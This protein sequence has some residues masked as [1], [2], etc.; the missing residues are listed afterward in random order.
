MRKRTL[1]ILFFVFAFIFIFAVCAGSAQSA[2]SVKADVVAISVESQ[3]EFVNPYSNSALAIHF[4]LEDGW[5]FYGAAKTAPGQTNLKIKT[6]TGKFINF[7][8]PIFPASH[9]YFDELSGK[10]IE[11]FSGDFTVYLPFKTADIKTVSKEDIIEEVKIDISGA[12]CSARQCRMPDFGRLSTQIKISLNREMGKPKFTLPKNKFIASHESRTTGDGSVLFALLLAFLAGLSL[13]IMPCVW[14]ILPIIVMQLAR[15][16]KTKS[17]ATGVSFC[18]GILLFFAALAGANIVLQIFYGTVLQWGDV[19]RNTAFIIGIS[20][21][22][23]VLALFC[24]GLFTFNVPAVSGKTELKKAGLFA[25]IGAGFLAAVLSTPCSFALLAAA[26]AWAQTQK[27]PLATLA[28]MT[29]GLGMALPY[30]ALSA[31]PKFLNRL[32]KPGKW[33]ELFKQAIGFVLLGIAVKLISALPVLKQ[34]NILYFAVVLG[35]CVWVW[36]SWVAHNTKRIRKWLIR[37]FAVAMAVFFGFILLRPSPKLID[38]QNYDSQKIQT[39]IKN[40]QPVLI[41]FTA[42]WCLSCGLVEKSVYSQKEIV[43]LLKD[44]NVLTIKADT[45]TSDSPATLA[46]KNIYNEPGVP[47]SLLFVPGR[48]E[49]VRWRGMFFGDKLKSQL[50]KL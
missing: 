6:I 23:V 31:V 18:I 38:W 16:S 10:K 4:H 29:M 15:Q 49:P 48:A 27:L 47:V 17:I 37:I 7:S 41:K 30:A 44:K 32:P 2:D 9:L 14:P 13:N 40:Q 50:E 28:I 20:I 24:F 33:M 19:L 42:S 26:F 35:F 36:S 5:H 45:T 39:A 46:L 25:A 43:K 22:L 8:E 1:A 12:V 3:H 21:L 34:A 11:V